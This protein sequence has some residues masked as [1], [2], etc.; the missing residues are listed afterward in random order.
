MTAFA[1]HPQIAKIAERHGLT[2][3]ALRHYEKMGL[4]FPHRAAT[5]RYYSPIQEERIRLIA[6]GKRLGLSLAQIRDAITPHPETGALVLMVTR[7]RALEQKEALEAEFNDLSRQVAYVSALVA[8]GGD[9]VL[10][11]PEMREGA[12]A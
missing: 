7:Q 6:T 11:A 4:L 9:P 8:G 1:S 2:A 3:R 10:M 5:R 12:R